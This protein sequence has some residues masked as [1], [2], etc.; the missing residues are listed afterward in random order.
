MKKFIS[1]KGFTLVELLLYIAI[2]STILMISV[3]FLQ[4]LLESKVKNQTMSEVE[5]QGLL[6]MQLITQTIRNS[7]NITL[8]TIGVSS[9]SLTLDVLDVNNDPTIFGLLSDSITIK[10]GAGEEIPITNSRVIASS[11]NFHNLSYLDTPG[12]VN[13]SFTLTYKNPENRQEY[14]FSKN[15][16]TSAALRQP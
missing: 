1:K 3:L 7:E 12:I 15:F 5:Q 6:V 14:N 10:E 16:Y 11:L 13:I 4:M 9:N 2:S 8:P